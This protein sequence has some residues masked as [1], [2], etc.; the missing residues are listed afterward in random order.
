MLPVFPRQVISAG[1]VKQPFLVTVILL[2]HATRMGTGPAGPTTAGQNP[3]PECA[4]LSIFINV[5]QTVTLEIRIKGGM[6]LIPNPSRIADRRVKDSI[7]T[8]DPFLSNFIQQHSRGADLIACKKNKTP[9][10]LPYCRFLFLR[11]NDRTT[12]KRSSSTTRVLGWFSRLSII[13]LCVK[14]KY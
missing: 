7:R 1:L 2:K 12:K 6:P 4:C 8:T 3:L 9:S 5:S 13:R 14:G 10:V 11:S